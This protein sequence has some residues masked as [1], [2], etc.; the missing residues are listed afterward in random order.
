[1]RELCGHLNIIYDLDWSKDDRYLVTS[2]SDGTARLVYIQEELT[3]NA[4][5]HQGKV[6][7][8]KETH[9]PLTS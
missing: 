6:R 8:Y 3:A 2:S 7:E 5:C 4:V 1:M 9:M